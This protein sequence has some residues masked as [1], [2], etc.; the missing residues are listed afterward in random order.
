MDKDGF[1]FIVLHTYQKAKSKKISF[2]F[3]FKKIINQKR[4]L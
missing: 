3:I 2:I 4:S 1:V